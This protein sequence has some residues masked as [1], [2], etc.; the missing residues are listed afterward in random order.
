M[1]RA[2]DRTAVF[3]TY[4]ITNPTNRDKVVSTIDEV[5]AQMSKEGITDEELESS[6]TSFLK[7][8]EDSLSDDAQLMSTLH[9][10][11]ES[12]RD[13]AFLARRLEKIKKL[14]KADI[15]AVLR[16]LLDVKGRV[17]VTAGDFAGKAK[18]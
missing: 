13:E 8:V 7:G 1:A 14:T 3:M 2:L 12:G 17:V 6:K 9:Q 10:Y 11:L 4:A 18:E 15:N 5:F 16:K